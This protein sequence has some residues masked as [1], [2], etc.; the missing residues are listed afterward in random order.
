MAIVIIICS[1]NPICCRHVRPHRHL[2]A[3]W[4]VSLS[5]SL[6]SSSMAFHCIKSSSSSSHYDWH[7]IVSSR[8]QCPYGHQWCCVLY[9]FIFIVVSCVCRY[10]LFFWPASP[11]SPVS[12]CALYLPSRPRASHGG[13]YHFHH[14]GDAP[15]SS[16]EGS[17]FVMF[18]ICAIWL[19][20]LI[21]LSCSSIIV[22]I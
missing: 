2:S 20:N 4:Y 6:L 19:A 17:Y 15:G 14:A 12:I 22:S 11:V 9:S 3:S 8:R 1:F 13:R 21:L 5:S 7:F 16:C 18:L 10:P